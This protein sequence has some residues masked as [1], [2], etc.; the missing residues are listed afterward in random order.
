MTLGE[1]YRTL[2]WLTHLLGVALIL[3]V[4]APGEAKTITVEP[5][6][7]PLERGH[8]VCRSITEALGLAEEGDTILLSPGVYDADLEE[9]PLVISI[10]L[11]ITSAAG[12]LATRVLGPPLATVFE[13]RASGVEISGITIVHSGR[14]LVVTGD[15][16]RFRGNR[17][18]L[19]TGEYK[20]GFAGMWVAGGRR[21]EITGNEFLRCGLCLAG[22]PVSAGSAGVAV[23]TGL[24]EVGADAD[25][26]QTHMIEDN[27]VNRK[28]LLFAVGLHDEE[29]AGGDYGQIIL[30]GCEN[31]SL[32]DLTISE[33][34][35]GLHVLHSR[36]ITV[37]DCSFS[38][39]SIF[40]ACFAY[41]LDC[42]IEDTAF[43][44]C[45]HGLDF[46]SAD[47]N[48]ASRCVVTNCGQGVFLSL[49]SFNYYEGLSVLDNGVGIFAYGS[50]ENIFTSSHVA[51]N[52]VGIYFQNAPKNLLLDNIITANRQSGL[53]F[54]GANAGTVVQ[55][56]RF[57][58]NRTAIVFLGVR[59]ARISENYVGQSV[60]TGIFLQ[61][62]QDTAIAGNLLLH[63]GVGIKL[64]EGCENISVS[65]N[66]F[67]GNEQHVV[68][69]S[70]GAMYDNRYD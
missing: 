30:V 19:H 33:A 2:R 1:K 54:H 17:V 70:V 45:N 34:S 46:R 51:Y 6:C 61:D 55:R 4:V 59:E 23:Y 52:D 66:S 40:G 10:P 32:S 12:P 37:T 49:S 20:L 67:S 36:N 56:N 53:R 7:Q 27:W 65:S 38:R 28:R 31:L 24:F 60:L 8:L 42:R 14:G 16:F 26:F 22:K 50:E 44:D 69:V 35:I 58:A 21:A 25:L 13:V 48:R 62:V 57:I 68:N 18:E 15:D 11:T 41:S 9:F 64:G 5:T 43:D 63:N 3:L 29:I 47:H 39:H